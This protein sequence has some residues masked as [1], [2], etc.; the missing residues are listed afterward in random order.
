MVLGMSLQSYTLLHVIISVIGIGSGLMVVYGFLAN[1]RLDGITAIFLTTTALTSLTGFLFPFK[2]VTP[3]IVVGIIS[4]IVLAI[5]VVARYPMHLAWR[6]T[7]VISACAALYFNL[8][9][10]VV[11]SLEKTPALKSLV[12]TEEP[13]FPIPQGVLF[14]LVVAITILSVKK[15]RGYSATASRPAAKAA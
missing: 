5:A 9:V 15:F 3:G 2:G 12:P 10:L 6:K 8:F 13:P 11:Q 4:L 14:V 1:R 7:Y